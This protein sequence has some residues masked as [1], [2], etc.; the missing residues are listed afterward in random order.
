MVQVPAV[1]EVVRAGAGQ[2]DLVHG[3]HRV[4]LHPQAFQG[5]G[6]ALLT[7]CST[8]GCARWSSSAVSAGRQVHLAGSRPQDPATGSIGGCGRACHWPQAPVQGQAAGRSTHGTCRNPPP[9][10]CQMRGA[11][12]PSRAPGAA[13]LTKPDLQTCRSCPGCSTLPGSEGAPMR[14]AQCWSG[15]LA[16]CAVACGVP[17]LTWVLSRRTRTGA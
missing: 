10:Q 8:A 15:L 9:S 2:L 3:V 5:S 1:W 11:P 17:A 6:L 14:R 16:S 4:V 12:A 13:D 7:R